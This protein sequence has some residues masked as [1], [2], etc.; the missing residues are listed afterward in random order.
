V[1]SP[2]IF[3]LDGTLVDSLPGIAASLNRSLTAHGLPGHSDAAIRSFVGN[4]ML[5]L[6]RRAAPTA[7]DPDLLA[8]LARFFKA[9]YEIS[10]PQGTSAY[11]GISNVLGDFQSSGHPLAVLSNKPHDFTVEMVSRVFPGVCFTM[12]LGQ[13]EAMPHKPDPS[14]ALLIAN[15]FGV[16]P[17]HCLVIG[18][19]TID[20][21]TATNAGMKAVAVAWG[22]HDEARL[23]AAGASCVAATVGELR[24][25]IAQCL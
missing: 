20:L 15:A 6:I 14:G 10:W 22:Y 13:R 11:P 18:D 1:K 19:S 8:S 23:L 3:D 7:A 5:T 9:D 12:V 16:A 21:E 4:G 24:D 25:R 2:L 17:E